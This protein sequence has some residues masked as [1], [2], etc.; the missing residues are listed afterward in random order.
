M[1]NAM[2][3]HC[4]E[5]YRPVKSRGLKALAC[6]SRLIV[7]ELGASPPGGLAVEELSEIKCFKTDCVKNCVQYLHF[8]AKVD[9]KRMLHG[10]VASIPLWDVYLPLIN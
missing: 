3:M 1:N 2:S 9:L 10:W 7:W 8:V 4:S 5:D 6:L